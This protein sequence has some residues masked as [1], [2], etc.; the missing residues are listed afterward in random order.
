VTAASLRSIGPIL[1]A[2]CI[3][4]FLL[5][6]LLVFAARCAL[7]GRPRTPAVEQRFP[8]LLAKGLQEW[9]IW[10]WGPVERACLHLGVTPN[11]ITVASAIVVG[12]AGGLVAAG[13][14]SLGGWLY[15]SGASLDLV[16]GRV[17][18]A[19]GMASRAGAFLDSTLDRVAEL[20]FFG[21]LALAYRAS[22]ILVAVLTAASASVLV[23]YTR[24]R[25]ESLGVGDVALTGWMQRPERIFL[26]GTACAL[27]PIADWIAGPGAASTVVGAALT[28]LAVLTSVTAARRGLAIFRALAAREAAL[29]PEAVPP[30]ALRLLR[31]GRRRMI[32]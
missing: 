32:R 17:A 7:F 26:T 25:G 14:V 9:W 19:T 5:S 27:S 11:A 3:A 23:S 29:R 16:D 22:P 12:V 6:T 30:T 1:P 4:A 2:L 28:L 31:P 8:S 10:L 24:A 18:R 13:F 20:L 21:G 15:L